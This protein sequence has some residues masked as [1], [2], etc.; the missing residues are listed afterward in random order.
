MNPLS[1]DHQKLKPLVIVLF[2]A[3]LWEKYFHI[4]CR[5]S[6]RRMLQPSQTQQ[7]GG[8]GEGVVCL[9]SGRPVPV[10]AGM[11]HHIN[12]IFQSP[13]IQ[14][15]DR[16]KCLAPCTATGNFPQF[17]HTYHFAT[18]GHTFAHPSHL[19]R[20]RSHQGTAL[21]YLQIQHPILNVTL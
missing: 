16:A 14:P 2:I 15:R 3:S 13:Q 1:T 18:L 7:K 21:I 6:F 11:H 4:H 17:P 9:C 5:V 8:G 10:T 20:Q 19:K 12:S